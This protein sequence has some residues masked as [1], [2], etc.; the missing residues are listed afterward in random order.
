MS[1]LS[2]GG[3]SMSASRHER[4]FKVSLA[5]GRCRCKADVHFIRE[6]PPS[7]SLRAGARH[8]QDI[9]SAASPPAR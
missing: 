8:R 3:A 9:C 1:R 4:K 6:D 5:N 2:F 7:A